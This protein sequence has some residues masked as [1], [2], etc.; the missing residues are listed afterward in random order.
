MCHDG[1]PIL[2]HK[3]LGNVEISQ[4]AE[5]E[6]HPRITNRVEAV[7]ALFGYCPRF[8]VEYE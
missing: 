6:M 2:V 7:L 1:S 4:S 3:S 8:P 5:Y